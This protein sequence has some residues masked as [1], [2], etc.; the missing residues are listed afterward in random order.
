LS[1]PEN[2]FCGENVFF[3]KEPPWV[4]MANISLVISSWPDTNF[5]GDKIFKTGN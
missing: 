1:H 3:S 2:G 5:M 4:D